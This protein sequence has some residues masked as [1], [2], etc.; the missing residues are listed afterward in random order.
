MLVRFQLR[1]ERVRL[2]AYLAVFAVMVLSTA[3][4]SEALYSTQAERDE[5][6]ATVAANQGLVALIGPAFAVDR[7]GGDVA[8]QLGG[9]GAVAAALMSMLLVGRHTR[10]EEESGRNELIRASAV[11]RG[12]PARAALGVAVLANVLLAAVL[13]LCVAAQGL[14][15]AV[16]FGAG[17]AGVGLV[18]TGLALVAMQLSQTAGGAYGLVGAALGLS[19][20]LRAAGDVGDGTLSWL[21]PVG[22]AQQMRPYADERWWPLALMLASFAVLTAVAFV[23]LERRDEG[24][25]ALAERPGAPHAGPGLART[26]GLALRLGRAS[27]I[28]WSAGFALSG[29]AIGAVAQDADSVLGDSQAVDELFGRAGGTPADQYLAVSL[30]SMALIGAAFGIAA[31]LK[32]RADERDGRAETLLATALDRPRWALGQALVAA[33]GTVVVLGV[34]GL[35]A[36]LADAAVTG[37]AGRIGPSLGA[38]VAWAPAVWVLLGLTVVLIGALPRWASAAWALL[39][40]VFGLALL[41]PL[42]GVPDWAL[43]LSP[44]QHV[45]LVPAAPFDAVPLLVL[46][47]VAAALTAAGILAL[48]RRDIAPH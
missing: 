42:L 15:G 2:P 29:L 23:L 34:G 41:G 47:L 1:R 45:P 25:G 5:Y 27:L 46:T 18:F 16:A 19:Y 12:A 7:V 35:G 4:Q 38:G 26:G 6:A 24:A 44:F 20:V 31:L 28:G 9:L 13:T 33:L 37:D 48:R 32:L 39:G 11:A 40:A 30:Q 22:W 17:V 21:S 43:D 36:G 3:A 10:A 8:W 14:T